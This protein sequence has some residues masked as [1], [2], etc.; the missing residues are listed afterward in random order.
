ME[1]VW[2]QRP[3]E[4]AGFTDAEVGGVGSAAVRAVREL[5]LKR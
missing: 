2:R 5:S 1:K 4:C 3:P